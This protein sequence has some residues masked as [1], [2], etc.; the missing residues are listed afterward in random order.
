[1]AG[2]LSVA[3]FHDDQVRDPALRPIMKLIK[4]TVDDAIDALLPSIRMRVVAKKRG[5]FGM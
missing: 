3:S 1:M 4:V 5:R 2:P